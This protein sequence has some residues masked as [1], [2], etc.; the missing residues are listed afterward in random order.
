MLE[1]PVLETDRL[2]IRPFTLADLDDAHRVLDVELA[3]A[4]VGSEGALTRGKRERWLSW[5]VLNYGELACLYQPPYGERAIVRK[6]SDE[7]IGAVGFVPCMAPFD[8][9][10][11]LR[12]DGQCAS[13]GLSRP[14]FGLFWAIAPEQQHDGYATEAARAMIAYAFDTLRLRR[15]IATT[16]YDNAASIGVMRKL[17]MSIEKNP[18]PEPPWLQIVGV[19]WHPT[20]A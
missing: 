19:L 9:I 2:R 11:A 13:A 4:D 12:M 15:I 3:D 18:L 14:E 1:M 7:L 6:H 10:P 8:Q 5:T 20:E 17:G 16:A